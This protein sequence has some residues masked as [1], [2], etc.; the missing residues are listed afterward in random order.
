M[1]YI[2]IEVS[3]NIR[4]FNDDH[5]NEFACELRKRFP[6]SENFYVEIQKHVEEYTVLEY[7]VLD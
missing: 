4:L 1:H 5:A 2:T 3:D 7:T 6:E